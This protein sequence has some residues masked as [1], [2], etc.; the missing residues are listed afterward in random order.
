MSDYIRFERGET[1]ATNS[2]RPHPTAADDCPNTLASPLA[3]FRTGFA[4]DVGA[5][6]NAEVRTNTH[7]S[8]HE[9]AYFSRLATLAGGGS[10]DVILED[11]TPP[12]VHPPHRGI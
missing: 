5:D 2:P 11:T 9:P 1:L 4:A 12:P 6:E 10:P 8:A 7:D 3:D